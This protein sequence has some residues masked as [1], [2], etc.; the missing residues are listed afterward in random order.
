MY[1]VFLGTIRERANN[2]LRANKTYRTYL[3]SCTHNLSGYVFLVYQKKTSWGMR[4]LLT[5]VFLSYIP[6]ISQSE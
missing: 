1:Y 6:K 5:K 4:V 2:F 3:F